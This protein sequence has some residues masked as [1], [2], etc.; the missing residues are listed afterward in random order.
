VFTSVW[1]FQR[2]ARG[3]TDLTTEHAQLCS[4]EPMMY[5]KGYSTKEQL[6]PNYATLS[7]HVASVSDWS[8]CDDVT[9]VSCTKS[10]VAVVTV[11]VDVPC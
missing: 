9:T 2:Y 7:V 3:Q 10:G 11:L 8:C 5:S 1:W 4:I 6:W